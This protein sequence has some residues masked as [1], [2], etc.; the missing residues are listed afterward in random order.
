[1]RL[2]TISTASLSGAVE[3][4]REKDVRLALLERQLADI[5]SEFQ[6][7][8][9][10]LSQN[11]SETA[12]S[13][14]SKHGDLN[15]QLLR[16]DT[17][18][19]LLREELRAREAETEELT[20]AW[21]DAMHTE[22]AARD[23]EIRDLRAQVR[24]LKEWVSTSTRADDMAST[25]DEVFSEGMAKISNGLQNWVIT[26]FRKSRVDLFKADEGTLRELGELVPTYEELARPAKVYLLQSIVSRLLVQRIFNL[27]F[28]GL[29]LKQEDQLR[30][31]ETI[32]AS[33]GKSLPVFVSVSSR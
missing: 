7:Q 32:M 30:Q 25:S 26:N 13:W 20:R 28:A 6:R 33:F 1:M 4:G 19:R 22:I 8:L 21:R 17:E 12:T 11:E 24:G 3:S 2:I 16:T 10:H 15:Q 9:A 18:L 14:R 23:Y 27:Y 29:S 31:T 5:E